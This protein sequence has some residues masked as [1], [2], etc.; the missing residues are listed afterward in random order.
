MCTL[1]LERDVADE[2]FSWCENHFHF[3]FIRLRAEISQR[4]RWN[5][6]Y[7]QRLHVSEKTPKPSSLTTFHDKHKEMPAAGQSPIWLCVTVHFIPPRLCVTIRGTK[8]SSSPSSLSLYFLYP[9]LKQPHTSY[10]I[11]FPQLPRSI[12][13]LSSAVRLS[14]RILGYLGF[15][16]CPL[17]SLSNLSSHLPAAGFN[18]PHPSCCEIMHLGLYIS[19]CT[20]TVGFRCPVLWIIRTFITLSHPHP[21][22]AR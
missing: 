1:Y 3:N 9:I 6:I 4:D 7:Q 22:T 5:Q 18:L 10:Y 11:F 15:H 2:L 21:H 12:Y 16:A 13:A 8:H 20:Y 17:H 14:Q 19:V